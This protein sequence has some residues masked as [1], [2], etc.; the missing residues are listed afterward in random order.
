MGHAYSRVH[1]QWQPGILIDEEGHIHAG[2]TACL[3]AEAAA[4]AKVWRASQEP[5]HD[6]EDVPM[7]GDRVVGSRLTP[8]QLQKVARL[9]FRGTSAQQDGVRSQAFLVVAA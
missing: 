8:E 1:E 3:Q 5:W 2:G 9:F 7:P 6:E 4:L